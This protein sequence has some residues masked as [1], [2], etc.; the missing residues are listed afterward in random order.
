MIA[1]GLDILRSGRYV[2]ALTSCAVLHEYKVPVGAKN[3]FESR[4]FSM[5]SRAQERRSEYV[6]HFAFPWQ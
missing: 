1:D 6:Q 2:A 4:P 5:H 3:E